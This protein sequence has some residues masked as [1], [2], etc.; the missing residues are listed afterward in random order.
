MDQDILESLDYG[1][2]ADY[3]ETSDYADRRRGRTRPAPRPSGRPVAPPAPQQGYVTRQEYTTAMERVKEQLTQAANG[4]KTV[5][6]RVNKISDSQEK[7]SREVAARKKEAE[8]L[9]KDLK[10]TREMAAIIPLISQNSRTVTIT[11]ANGTQQEVLAPSG[12]SIGAI[13]PLLLLGVG[14]SSGSGG[15]G[16]G[17]DNN[18]LMM[19]VLMSAMN[20]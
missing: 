16:G 4:I 10:S 15:L 2:D 1:S 11:G 17:G 9:R 19:V 3:L 7:L 8:A 20:R 5:D 18:M 6:G 14:D 12:N 13:A